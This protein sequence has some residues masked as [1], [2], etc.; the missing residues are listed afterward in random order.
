MWQP[1]AEPA[2]SSAG[3]AVTGTGRAQCL[4]AF[5]RVNGGSVSGFWPISFPEQ[6][7]GL[8][9]M[10]NRESLLLRSTGNPF[11]KNHFGLLFRTTFPK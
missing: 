8:M 2:V 10:K 11:S 7:D 4:A 9:M 6:T 1:V 3:V 5:L